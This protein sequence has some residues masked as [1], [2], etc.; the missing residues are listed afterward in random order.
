MDFSAT[1]Q[2]SRPLP[3]LGVSG[4]DLS[5]VYCKGHH[6]KLPIQRLTLDNAKLAG[7]VIESFGVALG[8]KHGAMV[9]DGLLSDVFEGWACA[10]PNLLLLK[11]WAGTIFVA[12]KV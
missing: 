7:D 8:E 3:V 11:E 12:T 6:S 4:R 2:P 1:A 5:S 10:T 9:V